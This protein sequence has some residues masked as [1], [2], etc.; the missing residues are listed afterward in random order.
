MV[1]NNKILLEAK[2]RN[3]FLYGLVSSRI[4][5]FKTV[6]SASKAK[7]SFSSASSQAVTYSSLI[8]DSYYG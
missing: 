1:G 5:S 6:N 7:A 8:E 4:N 3:H 2:E